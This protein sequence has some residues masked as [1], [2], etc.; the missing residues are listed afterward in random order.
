MGYGETIP[1]PRSPQGELE[2]DTHLR[3]KEDVLQKL[4]CVV[5]IFKS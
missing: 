4:A 3:Y 5:D 1:I 2:D